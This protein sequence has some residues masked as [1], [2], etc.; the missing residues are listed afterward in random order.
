MTEYVSV[1]NDI[2]ATYITGLKMAGVTT[3]YITSAATGEVFIIYGMI[4]KLSSIGV[5][6]KTSNR[7][8]PFAILRVHRKTYKIKSVFKF[9][10]LGVVFG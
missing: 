3:K 1:T 7:P 8:P 4:Y 2:G 5:D 6:L 9:I 10:N